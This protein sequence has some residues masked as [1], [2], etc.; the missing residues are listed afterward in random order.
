M[1]TRHLIAV[2]KDNEYKVAQYGQWDGYLEGQGIDI[3]NFLT[4]NGNIELL[5]TAM[6]KVRY[7]TTEEAKAYNKGDRSLVSDE[8]FK[9]F[10]SRELGAK[11]LENI[12]NSQDEEIILGEDLGFAKKSLFCEWAYVIDLDDNTFEVFKGF[13]ET[14]LNSDDRFFFDGHC[15]DNGYKPVKLEK[16]F[17][18]DKLPEADE[19]LK[20]EG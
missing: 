13:N 15:E 8:Y 20:L 19:F 5:R 17:S 11:I 6:S 4:K 10:F 12:I 18:L 9:N 3:L 7:I 14:A 16:K 2:M 1:G